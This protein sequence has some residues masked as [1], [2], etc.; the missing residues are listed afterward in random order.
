MSVTCWIGGV[1][2][3]A[4]M[5]AEGHAIKITN[6]AGRDPVEEEIESDGRPGA[7]G[8]RLVDHYLPAREVAVSYRLEF[9]DSADQQRAARLLGKLIGYGVQRCEFSDQDGHYQALVRHRPDDRSRTPRSV[10]G[11]LLL[12]CPQPFLYGEER[13]TSPAGGVVEVETNRYVEPV[14][15]WTL[16]ADVGAAW[17]EVDGER[18]TIDTGISSGQQIRIDCSR[19]ET[20]VGGVLNVENINGVYPQMRDGSTIET[21]PGGSLSITYE[22]RYA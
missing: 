7:D 8:V 4:A 18:L 14:I 2:L 3:A 16:D 5:A 12:Y 10:R 6:V 21:S 1:D 11:E 13:T 19:Q 9:T 22:A 20:R 15:L 17:V